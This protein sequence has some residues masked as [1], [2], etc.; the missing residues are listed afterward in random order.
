MQGPW[1]WLAIVLLLI[2]VS[3]NM[4]GQTP[5]A[6]PQKGGTTTTEQPNT[7]VYSGRDIFVPKPSEKQESQ[8][9]A[10]TFAD[11]F[12]RDTPHHLG[13]S[14]GAFESYTPGQIDPSNQQT[15]VV[16]SSI[17]PQVFTNI[18]K[19]SFDFRLNYGAI[20]NRYNRALSNLDSATQYGNAT[21]NYTITRR[22]T[23]FHVAGYLSSFYN[24]PASFLGSSPLALLNSGPQ[25]YVQRRRETTNNVQIG[26]SHSFTKKFGVSL[27]AND[28]AVRYSGV[29][30]IQV[31][32]ITAGTDYRINKWMMFNLRYS[33]NVSYSEAAPPN[34]NYEHLQLA[35]FSFKLRGGWQVSS[36][37]GID[38]TSYSGVRSVTGSGQG[39][40]TK[41]S[42]RTS[43]GVSYNRGY[44]TAFPSTSILH[45]DS[46]TVNVARALSS[47]VSIRASAAY[48]R[49]STLTASS[50]SSTVFGTST[51]EFA[52]H[53]DLMLSVNHF[54]VSQKSGSDIAN[55]TS[56]HNDTTSVGL[57]FHM[58]SFSN[59]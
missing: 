6:P 41:V 52:L 13:F 39:S 8:E 24:D 17:T 29:T 19:K 37:G 47:R 58:P 1:Q 49:G 45:G 4:Y 53:K 40:I 21:V 7:G 33:H 43:I 38:L 15:G 34:T 23:G 35:G 18:Q 42:R 20:F 27:S 16:L 11:R 48:F 31:L 57:M 22:K 50:N 59:R 36:S 56:L 3:G 46:G 55:V 25:F 5:P 9:G 54:L 51:L 44:S 12:L 28:L 32:T 26:L 2:A 10:S 14:L 30:P